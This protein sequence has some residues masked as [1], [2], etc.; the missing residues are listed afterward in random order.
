MV[1]LGIGYCA[2]VMKTEE[3]DGAELVELSKND[4][5]TI[6]TDTGSVKSDYLPWGLRSSL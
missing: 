2:A 1:K 4:F 5:V 6:L 3:V